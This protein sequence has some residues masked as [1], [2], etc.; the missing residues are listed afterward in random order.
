MENDTL[1]KKLKSAHG[2]S[3]YIEHENHKILFDLGPNNYFLKNAEVLGVNLKEVDIVI[4]SHG[5]FD[6]GNG[7]RKFMGLIQKRKY[8]YQIKLLINKRKKSEYFIYQLE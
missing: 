3:M 8:I 4:I 5:H 7:L 2:L 6:H 1:D